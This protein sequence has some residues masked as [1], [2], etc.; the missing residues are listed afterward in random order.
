VPS[1]AAYG[2]GLFLKTVSM[3]ME[4]AEDVETS[5]GARA[6]RYLPLLVWMA[7]IFF[8][9]TGELSGE[10]TSRI[11]RPLL[12][13]LFPD[14]SVERLALAHLLVRKAAHFTEYAILALLAARAFAD[15]SRV[16]LRRRWFI[17]SLLLVILYALSDEFHQTFV[18]SRIGSI[19]DSFI[20][21]S[22]GLTALLLLSVRHRRR[23]KRKEG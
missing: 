12:L 15:S 14:I 2:T 9:S 23:E 17:A 10:N 4:R 18:P 21:M 3:L 11:V 8:F 13:W 6:W 22:G 5:W 20:D 16:L 1:V 7:L 19:Y